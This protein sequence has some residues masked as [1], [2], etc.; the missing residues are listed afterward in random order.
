MATELSVSRSISPEHLNQWRQ[1][2]D[3]EPLR[4]IVS[5]AIVKNG[6]NGVAQRRERV[7][8]MT[9]A[10]SHEIKTGAITNQ[11][12]S[13]R[14]WLFAGLNMIRERMA[15]DLKLKDLELSQPYLMFYDKLEKSNYFL[16]SI[17]ETKREPVDGRLVSWLLAAP[18]QDGGQWDMFVNLVEKYGIVPKWIMP[19]SFHSSDSRLMNKIVTTKLRE[20]AARL[21]QATGSPD[22]LRALKDTMMADIY[23]LLAEFLGEPP[24]RFDFEYQDDEGG[25]HG[26]LGI[27]PAEFWNRYGG[28]KLGDYVSVI[29]A[30]TPDKPFNAPYTVDYLGNV[31]GG[32]SVFYLNLPNQRFK[33]LAVEQL[34]DARPVW[35]GCDV[36][37]MSDRVT[38]ILD[39]AQYDYAGTL[40]VDFTMTKGDRLMY[41]ESLMTHAMLL[42]GVNLV[43]GQPNRWKV[44]NSWG[45]DA[46]QDGLFVMSDDW[47]DNYMYQV[48]VDKTYLTA[49]EREMLEQEPKHLPPW[50]PM[51]SLA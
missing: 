22:E 7:T 13:G 4:K 40:G 43:E 48:V 28:V 41:G 49:G 11:K 29:N 12:A 47:F 51:G 27:S 18:I 31:V 39:S 5:N 32:R 26:D 19:E 1:S 3:Q 9:F 24:S 34:K 46:G 10:F 50:D 8:T 36:G 33:E 6:I 37:P 16:E 2:F 15:R 17:L 38:G 44:E 21:R 42:T 45:K 30:P 25:Y 14:C 20:D 23:Q 35:F